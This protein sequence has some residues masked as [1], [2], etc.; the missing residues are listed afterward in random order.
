MSAGL[1][2]TI[3]RDDVSKVLE[4]MKELGARPE[5]VLRAMG[6]EFLGIT[7]R[8]FGSAGAHYRPLE[9]AKRGDNTPAT[10]KLK[11][12]L[13]QQFHLAV[14]S[15]T[16]TVSNPMQYAA[17]HQFGGVIVPKTKKALR[18]QDRSGRW[19]TKKK[20]VMPPRPFFPVLNDA[21]T[22]QASSLIARTGERALMRQVSGKTG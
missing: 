7:K 17:I 8:N 16:A 21:L 20:V 4:R 13:Y 9:W 5:P 6:M 11:G 10:L 22:P 19:H 3:T 15:T 14:S 1:S 2:L 12:A 18:F